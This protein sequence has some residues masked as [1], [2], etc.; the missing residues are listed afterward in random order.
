MPKRKD[1]YTWDQTFMEMSDTIRKRSKDP[2]TQVGAVI[3]SEDNRILSAG[4][5]GTPVGCDDDSF[6]WGKEHDNPLENKYLFVIHAERNAV[7]NYRGNMRD[8][9]GSTCY[10][11]HYPCI[12][13]A[14]ELAQAGIKR[15]VFKED[16]GDPINKKA[17]EMI[18][19]HAQ[20]TVEKY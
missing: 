19:S 13:C 16:K 7:L 10:V 17:C 4:Y 1:Y 18:F 20:I 6:P 5:N 14:K 9:T 12:E 2:C 11:T 15:I 8:L 3:V